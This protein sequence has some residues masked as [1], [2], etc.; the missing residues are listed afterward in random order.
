V[1]RFGGGKPLHGP[2]S[3]WVH[4]LKEM[5]EQQFKSTFKEVPDSKLASLDYKIIKGTNIMR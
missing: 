2:G 5:K 4:Y 3:N 1:R